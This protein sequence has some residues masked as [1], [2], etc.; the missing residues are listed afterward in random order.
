MKQIGIAIMGIGTVGGGTYDILTHNRDLIR[1]TRGL[2]LEVRKILDRSKDN[3]TARGI[4]GALACTDLNEI[5]S[6]PGISVVVETMGGVEPARTF[7][8][9]ALAAGKSVVTANKELISKHGSEL[10]AAAKKSGAGLYYEASCVGGVPI[11]R[12]LTDSMQAN[13]ITEIL[14]IINGTTNY[15]LTKM[16]GEGL[17]YEAA[18]RE[19]QQLGYAEAD[20]TADVEG[21]DA[22]YK[23]SILSSMAFHTCIPYTEIYREGITAITPADIAVG[24]ELGYTLK[25]LAIGKRN[26]REIEARVH[27]TFVPDEHPLASVNGSF[28]AVF[29]KGDFV[30]DIMLYGRGAGA[31]PTGSAIVSDIVTCAERAP[32]HRYSDY[33]NSGRLEEGIVVKRDFSSRYY[34]SFKLMD[35]PGVLG[36][37]TGIL[38]DCGVS[39]HKAMQ[40]GDADGYAPVVFFTHMTTENAVKKALDVIVGLPDVISLDSL[41]RVL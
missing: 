27:P 29:L 31:H 1:R 12:T 4:D 35:K 30:D 3:V 6:D 13:H 2:D 7:I 33:D 38:G 15:I 18:L 24:R 5:V 39:I 40:H 11:I 28:N 16:S 37:I 34:L 41:I 26:G 22:M 9:R 32:H 10:E 20:P 17:S 21:Y 36:R 19:A 23:L 14:G 8:L 25:L